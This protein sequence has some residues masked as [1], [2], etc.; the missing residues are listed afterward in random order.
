MKVSAAW[1]DSQTI[2]SEGDTT[3]L[4]HKDKELQLSNVIE[5][6]GLTKGLIS[7]RLLAD[8][9]NVQILW[10]DKLE[11]YDVADLYIPKHIK[12]KHVGT[13]DSDGAWLL[14]SESCP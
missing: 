8:Q 11:I 1:G 2:S 14:N 9:G 12:P 10:P 4:G 3:I 5:V 13:V 6:P 7:S